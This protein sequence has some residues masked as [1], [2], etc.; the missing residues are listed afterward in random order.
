MKDFDFAAPTSL[1][2]AMDILAGANGEARCLAGG[3]DLI[4]QI[5]GERKN[6]LLVVDIKKIPELTR[7]HTDGAG[8]HIG[9]AASCTQVYGNP[10]V[11]RKYPILVEC[12]SIVGDVKIQN[13][14]SIGGNLCNAAPSADTASP[15]LVLEAIAIIAGKAGSRQ[16]PIEKFF[17]G[18]GTNSL[19]PGEILLEILVPEPAPNSAAH[20]LRFTPR[21]EM[22]IAIAGAASLIQAKGNKIGNAR[23]GLTSVAPV[24]L[25]G[26][27]AESFLKGREATEENLREAGNIASSESRPIDDIRGTAAYRKE[28]IKVLVYRTLHQSAKDLNIFVK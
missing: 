15:L 4:D 10:D 24:P 19:E 17:T 25:R 6:P 5:R 8:L 11:K 12:S 14:A 13:R 20:Y 26:K 18:P 23:I 16:L 7:L 22:D 3:T 21:A 1:K 9:A 28:L 2:E 27:K